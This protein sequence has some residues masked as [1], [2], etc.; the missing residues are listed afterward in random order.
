MNAFISQYVLENFLLHMGDT[1]DH[2][3]TAK[4]KNAIFAIVSANI[5]DFEIVK[6]ILEIVKNTTE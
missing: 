3:E 6:N 5:R 2:V 1:E 4:R